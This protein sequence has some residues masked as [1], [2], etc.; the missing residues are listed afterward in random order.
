MTQKSAICKDKEQFPAALWWGSFF[1]CQ[2]QVNHA[3]RSI[4]PAFLSPALWI[5]ENN[6]FEK[7]QSNM[8]RLLGEFFN[9]NNRQMFMPWWVGR[10]AGPYVDIL[11][12]GKNFFVKADLPGVDMEDLDISVSDKA[13]II[14][15]KVCAEECGESAHYIRRECCSG[16]F[17]R[18]ISLPDD[19]DL[20]NA[21][22][23]FRRNVL[24]VE[25]PRKTGVV[26]KVRKVNIVASEWKQKKVA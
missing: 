25:V 10:Q 23:I 5:M 8:N 6:I 12:N 3:L 1:E 17:N 11:E 24:I 9:I 18:A 20:D 13:L 7:L 14:K 21:E 26:A 2:K 4:S 16:S 22:A 19:A 15:G